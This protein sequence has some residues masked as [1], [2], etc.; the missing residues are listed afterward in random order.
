MFLAWVILALFL[1]GLGRLTQAGATFQ[2]GGF[3]TATDEEAEA[4]YFAVGADAMI[5]VKQGAGLQRWLK[6]HSGQRVRL[7]FEPDPTEGQEGP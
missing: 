1:L 3:V 2:T 6:E 5:V 7:V 4:G